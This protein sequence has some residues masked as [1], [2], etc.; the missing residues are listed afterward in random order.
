MWI[1]AEVFER[2]DT[3]IHEPRGWSLD[4]L[5][6]VVCPASVA[7]ANQRTMNDA[8]R[9]STS[10][11]ASPPRC[12]STSVSVAKR[13]AMT[14]CSSAATVVARRRIMLLN[15]NVKWN[16][17]VAARVDP[18]AAERHTCHPGG[19]CT[20][21]GECCLSWQWHAP[22][23]I[24]SRQR[25]IRLTEISTKIKTYVQ[26]GANKWMDGKLTDDRTK[27]YFFLVN[28]WKLKTVYKTPTSSLLHIRAVYSFLVLKFK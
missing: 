19:Q 14:Q 3:A 2:M 13:A 7:A 27:F 25:H 16:D 22:S 24:C 18:M 20:A 23:K 17:L 10:V 6:L 15:E 11:P 26:T 8:G 1:I 21:V 9:M 12:P 28:S 5:A 4:S